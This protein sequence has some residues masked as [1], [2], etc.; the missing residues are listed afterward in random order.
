VQVCA[1]LARLLALEFLDLGQ[2]LTQRFVGRF[3]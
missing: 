3:H 1:Q 2:L